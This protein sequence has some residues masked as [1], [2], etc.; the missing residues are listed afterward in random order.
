MSKHNVP[1]IESLYKSQFSSIIATTVDFVSLIIFTELLGIYYLISTAMASALGA[2]VSFFLGR[3]WAFK[4]ADKNVYV[5]ALKYAVVSGFILI[6]NVG[7]MYLFTDIFNIQYIFS[8]IIVSII[9]GIFI[10]FPLFRYFVY[11]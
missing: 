3:H 11:R 9:I 7:G 5:Q 4:K 10:S 2:I 1:F 8:K 6:C